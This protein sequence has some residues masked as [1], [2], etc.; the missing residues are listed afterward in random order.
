MRYNHILVLGLLCAVMAGGRTVQAVVAQTGEFKLREDWAAPSADHPTTS[1]ERISF[2]FGGKP[3]APLLKDWQ[4]QVR[5]S[6]TANSSTTSETTWTDPAT[7]LEVRVSE[8]L[9]RDFPAVEWVATLKNTGTKDTPLI[10]AVQAI[11]TTFTLPATAPAALHWANGGLANFDDF[12]PHTTELKPGTPFPLQ[13]GEGRSSSQVLPFFNLEGAGGGVVLAV[14][15]SGNWAARFEADAKGAVRVIAGQGLTRLV[16]HPGEEIRTPRMLAL[17]YQ[18]DRWRGQNLLRR[19]ILA[20]H[21]PLKQGQPM[22]SPITAGNWG[23]TRAEVHLD[24]I[25]KFI[26]ERL[27]IEYYWIDA[28]WYGPPKV[29]DVGSWASNVGDWT[30]KTSL[31]PQGFKPLSDAQREVGRELML[32]FEP[33]RVHAGTPWHREHREWLIDT[34]DPSLLLDLGR[35]DARA[36]VTDFISSRITEYGLG[37]YRQDFNMDP[38]PSWRK[39]DAPDRQGMTENR[40]VTGLYAFWDA[41]LARHPNLIIDN[42]ASGGRRIDLE[43]VGR[44]TPFWRSD[45]PRDPIAHQAHTYGLMEWVPLSAT[46]Q[47]R[48]GDD[49]EFRSSM[50]SSLCINWE[51][52]GDGPCE[53]IRADFPFDWARKNTGSVCRVRPRLLLRRLLPPHP[54][55]PG[56]RRMDGLPTRPPGAGRRFGGRAAPAAEPL[57][58]GALRPPRPRHRRILHRHQPRHRRRDERGRLRS[59]EGGIPSHHHRSTGV[60]AHHIPQGQVAGWNNEPPNPCSR[61]IGSAGFRAQTEDRSHGMRGR[62][63]M[64]PWDRETDAEKAKRKSLRVRH[65]CWGSGALIGLLFGVCMAAFRPSGH[66]GSAQTFLA[67]CLMYFVHWASGGSVGREGD[68]AFADVAY[69]VWLEW[70]AAGF[71]AGHFFFWIWARTNP[72]GKR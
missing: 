6:D 65:I 69:Y 4:R 18:G 35:P 2:S 15:W 55:H 54:V 12:A 38:L 7:G 9:F 47:D 21:R 10:E 32:W 30:I 53:P 51:H 68:E 40:H 33:E 17:F 11:D 14:G 34:G 60:V 64:M 46:S 72:K 57:R 70:A 48:A 71:L 45:G 43:T 29:E 25:R 13:A 52:S 56:T 8:Q 22:I 19:F 37:C 67:F 44:A 59:D 31:Y 5:A 27:P 42:C 61:A 49:Y 28:G 39:T 36:F 24:N 23:G 58:D 3:G 26:R 62:C 66:F 50:C 20:H 1:C 41:L 63:I 16:L